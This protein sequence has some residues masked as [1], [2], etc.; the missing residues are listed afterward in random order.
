[1]DHVIPMEEFHLG[2]VERKEAGES[3]RDNDQPVIVAGETH[4]LMTSTIQGSTSSKEEK[5]KKL[6]EAQAKVQLGTT[7]EIQEMGEPTIEGSSSSKEEKFKKLKEAQAKVQLGTTP[8]I[9]EMGEPTIEGSSSSKEEKFKKLKEAQV[10]VQLGTTLEIQEVLMLRDHKHYQKYCEPRVVS[11][12]PIHH[13]KPKYQL[14]EVYKL[15]LADKFIGKTGRTDEELYGIIKDKIKGLRECYDEKV[16]QKYSDED[17]AWMLFVDGCATL[18]F[19]DLVAHH[20]NVEDFKIKNDQVAFVQQDLFLLENQLP[21]KLLDYLM[22]NIKEE[23]N[24]K[25]EKNLW[26]S[27]Q[28]FIDMH[29]MLADGTEFQNPQNAVHLLDLLWKR[30]LGLDGVKDESAQKKETGEKP[31][32]P[33]V[34]R[35]KARTRRMINTPPN[36]NEENDERDLEWHS[37]RNVQE[38]REVGIH[39]K[40]SKSR[41]LRDIEFTKKCNFYPGILWMPKIVVDDSTGPMFFNLIA[42]EMCPDFENDFGIT[43]YIY[44]L[45]SL[46]DEQKD[47][48]DLRNAGILH[49]LLGSD[50]EVADV[51]NEIGTDLVPNLDIYR[52]VRVQIQKYYKMQKKMKISPVIHTHFSSPWTVIAFVAAFFAL[53]LTVVQTVYSILAYYKG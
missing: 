34:K 20:E 18:Q 53:G 42:Y 47:V 40:H 6:K 32:S 26:K 13:G 51:F 1:M 8:E 9:Q 23:E 4:K 15:M 21:Y 24:R 36:K 10:K 49:N 22:K 52:D 43:S 39:L 28:I 14:T 17:L 38:L 37:F 35:S 31:R 41:S 19:I 7:P 27:I 16:T 45:D 30:L 46:I 44:F 3:S 48:I 12:G 2:K 11:L 25:M 33:T 5:F 50:Q 29:S